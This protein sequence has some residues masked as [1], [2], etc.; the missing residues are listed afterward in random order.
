MLKYDCIFAVKF[1]TEIE[2]WK[3]LEN[4]TLELKSSYCHIFPIGVCTASLKKIL[5]L[6]ETEEWKKLK[7]NKLE[8]KSSYCYEVA[9]ISPIEGCVLPVYKKNLFLIAIFVKKIKLIK[10]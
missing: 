3:K 6:T 8:L 7:N 5:L 9:H 2:E 1:L 10:K 4:N